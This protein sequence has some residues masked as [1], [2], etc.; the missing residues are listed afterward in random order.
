[1]ASDGGPASA[2]TPFDCLASG[3]M[4]ADRQTGL[5][6]Y[7]AYSFLSRVPSGFRSQGC[8][9]G[10]SPSISDGAGGIRKTTGA[11]SADEDG[12]VVPVY[13]SCIVEFGQKRA[14]TRKMLVVPGR[15]A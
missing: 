11:G 4:D 10:D 6:V 5:L 9:T 1:M 12:A 3:R 15:I 14:S 2:S 13:T 7:K 8:W